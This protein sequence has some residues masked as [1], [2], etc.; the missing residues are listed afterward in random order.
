MLTYE[1]VTKSDAIK[2]YIVRADESLA[3][4]KRFVES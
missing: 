3:A 2:T 4:L 1:E